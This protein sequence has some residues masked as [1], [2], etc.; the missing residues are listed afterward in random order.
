MTGKQLDMAEQH[1][2]EEKIYL[3]TIIARLVEKPDLVW[4]RYVR[5]ITKRVEE[6]LK[7]L[8]FVRNSR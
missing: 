8:R 1:L 7:M 3:N 2:I 4:S 5:Y 6:D